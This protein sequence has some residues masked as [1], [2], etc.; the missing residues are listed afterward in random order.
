MVHSK[1][2]QLLIL[3]V[4][5]SIGSDS[6]NVDPYLV[7]TLPGAGPVSRTLSNS[8]PVTSPSHDD[9]TKK[10]SFSPV[11]PPA[12]VKQQQLERLQHNSRPVSAEG[13]YYSTVS[14]DID[15]IL[16]SHSTDHLPREPSPYEE[17]Y[18]DRSSSN[19]NIEQ[20]EDDEEDPI[21]EDILSSTTAVVKSVME[22][23]NKLQSAK[24]NDYVELVKVEFDV[25]PRPLYDHTSFI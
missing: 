20:V 21:T 10:K 25:E 13:V 14:S 11:P 22:L 18:N 17:S 2:Y 6:S 7:T 5:S 3:C 16:P 9:L 12:I 8:S 1:N 19:E 24:P 23:S 4:S 15:T